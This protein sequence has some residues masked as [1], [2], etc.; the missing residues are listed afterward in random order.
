MMERILE[1]EYMDTPEEAHGYDAMDHSAANQSVVSAFLE[2]GGDACREILDIGTGPGDIPLLLAAANPSARITAVD[3][4][5]T[6]LGLARQKVAR[7]GLEDRITLRAADAKSL[8][9]DDGAFD[10]VISNTILHHIPDPV[11][12]LAEAGRVLG[13]GT[14]LIRDLCRPTDRDAA[15][16]LVALHAAQENEYQQKLFFDSLCASLTLDEVRDALRRAGL[17]DASLAMTSDRHYT[18]ALRR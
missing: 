16:R 15:E 10:G 14:L 11:S 6:M 4:A 5:E 13:R 3:A 9:F 2:A 8:P 12:Y 7:A 1:P 17:A 18:I